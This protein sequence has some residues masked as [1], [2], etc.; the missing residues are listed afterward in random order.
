MRTH[1]ADNIAPKTPLPALYALALCV[2][3]AV[4]A[5]SG[6]TGF[7]STPVCMAGAK[8]GPR[9]KCQTQRAP[10]HHIPFREGF[11]T[12][13]MQGFHG[14]LS[15]KED[16]A[17][18]I[19][20]RCKEGTPITASKSGR[21]WAIREDSDK[22]CPDPSCVEDAN[23]VILDH[24]DG[25]Y[26][27]YYHLRELGALVEPGEQVCAGQVI[28]LCGNTGF[29]SGPHL[30]FALTDSTRH[31]VPVRIWEARERGYGF[32]VPE[33][34]YTS[35]NKIRA[36]CRDR[37]FS[38]IPKEAFAHHGVILNGELPAVID[39]PDQSHL[40]QGTY[41][42]DHPNIAIHRKLIDGGSWI[43]ECVPVDED[44]E[45]SARIKWPTKRFEAG[46]YWFM[47][48]GADKDCLAPGWAWSYKVQVWE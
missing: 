23:Y 21:V 26:S 5:A 22:G 10:L 29:S 19:D 36:Q 48:T 37:G 14:Y 43:D 9:G 32:V 24:G 45:F 42:G 3:A 41:H 28:G 2:L 1:S 34:E 46:T 17:F 27:E 15:H 12:K 25:T 16:L 39:D 11:K 33:T 38:Q 18:S 35:E 31:T 20:Y 30:H 4:V 7:G 8:L 47:I 44:G 6:C 40:V 13:V